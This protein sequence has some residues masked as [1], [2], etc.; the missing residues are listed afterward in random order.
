MNQF[1]KTALKVKIK[2]EMDFWVKSK[3]FKRN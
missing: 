2:K 3:L 1:L